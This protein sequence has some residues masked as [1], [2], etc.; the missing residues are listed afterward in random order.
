MQENV[1]AH[2]ANASMA[3]LEKAQWLPLR[4]YL[5]E[6]I[7]T[8]GLQPPRPPRYKLMLSSSS[9]LLLLLLLL[10]VLLSQ[11]FSPWYFS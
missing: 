10:F 6:K 7:Q 11:A 8:C 4:K 2:T 1:M 9:S 5:G 3:A